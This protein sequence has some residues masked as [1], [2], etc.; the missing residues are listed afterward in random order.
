VKGR[1]V[2]ALVGVLVVIAVV[3]ALAAQG[4]G[5]ATA[6]GLAS[7][8]PSTTA[9]ATPARSASGAPS[10]TATANGSQPTGSPVVHHVWI[11][12]MENHSYDQVVGSTD[13]P[14]LNRLA[15]EFGMAT[16]YHAVARPSE[17]N[18]L[19]LVSGSTQGV[20]DDAIHDITAPTVFDQ[21]EAAGHSWRV[22]AEHVPGG[23][24]RGATAKGGPDGSGTYARKHEPA[25]SFTGI[26]A[27]PDRCANIIDFSHF[28]PGAA[29]LNL[30]VPD[31][32]H[33]MHDCSVAAGDEWLSG[34]IPRITG[35]AAFADGGLLVVT[36]DEASGRDSSQHVPL[37]F[38]GPS[39]AAG[40]QETRQ[41][42][43][44]DLLR[45]IQA[46]FGLG[47]LEE[48]CHAQPMQALLGAPGT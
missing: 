14:F 28:D 27:S 17:P 10:A 32:C 31:M 36:F 11:V 19:A 44:Y 20:T 4:G 15:G 30:I 12:V 7:G 24:F 40:T 23:C 45:T 1:W 33:D 35:S 37:V 25:I 21:L 47:C 2:L 9:S 6:T 43:H 16:D 13:A 8:S 42:T 48:S 38:A 39:V 5:G 26:S 46:A 29:D 3:G 34:F 18:Y 41:A 22:Y